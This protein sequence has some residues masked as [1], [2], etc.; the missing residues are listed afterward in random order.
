MSRIERNDRVPLLPKDPS[1]IIVDEI[2]VGGPSIKISGIRVDLSTTLA[3]VT[4]I[5]VGFFAALMLL[6]FFLG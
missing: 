6:L 5:A 2:T 4:G 1:G 3:F